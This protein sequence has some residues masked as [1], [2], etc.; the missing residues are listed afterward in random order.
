MDK[1]IKISDLIEKLNL[2]SHSEFVGFVVHLPVS[3][4]FLASFDPS[5]YV[6]RYMWVKIPDLAYIFTTQDQAKQFV[7]FYGKSSVVGLLFDLGDNY[8]LQFPGE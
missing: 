3:D 4:E 8:S 7:N 5:L 2:P 1:K 6:D